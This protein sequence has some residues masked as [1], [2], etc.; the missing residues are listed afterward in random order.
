VFKNRVLRN[1]FGPKKKEVTGGIRKLHNKKLH[2]LYCSP[3]IIKK[4]EMGEAH[5]KYGAEAK[6]MK[7][8]D[9]ETKE[10]HQFEDL[11]TDETE[12]TRLVW[13]MTSIRS[14]IL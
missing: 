2:D 8:F 14:M 9:G 6:C 11:A 1:T 7:G 5:R 13:L 12:W 10:R 4:D 3:N